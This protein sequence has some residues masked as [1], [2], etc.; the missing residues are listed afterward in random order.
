MI[1][2]KCVNP[3]CLAPNGTFEWDEY[4]SLE[5]DGRMAKQGDPGAKSFIVECSYCGTRNKIWLVKLREDPF[6]RGF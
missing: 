4:S 6:E 1:P 3:K 2:I 5:N